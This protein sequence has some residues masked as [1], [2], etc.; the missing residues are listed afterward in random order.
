[1]YFYAQK[2]Y[3]SNQARPAYRSNSDGFDLSCETK[4]IDDNVQILFLIPSTMY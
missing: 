4:K 1:M 2:I 3:Y